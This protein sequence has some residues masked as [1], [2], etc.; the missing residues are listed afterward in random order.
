MFR[1]ARTLAI[2]GLA[3]V[4]LAA[5]EPPDLP[6]PLQ[7]MIDTER[8]FAETASRKGIRDSFL[9]YFAPDSVAFI[10]SPV[11]A[12]DRLL[13]QPPRPA[14]EYELRWEPRAGDAASSGDLGWLTGPSTFI[15]HTAAD[16]APQHGNY[17]SIWRRQPDGAWRV[18]IDVGA[19]QPSPTPFPDGFTQVAPASRYSRQDT[20][21]SA[22]A[23]LLAADR[24]LDAALPGG[25]PA[26]YA[27]RLEPQ[28]RLH[29]PGVTTPVG[30]A[31]IGRWLEAHAAGMTAET[32]GGETSAAGDLGYT[33]GTYALPEPSA[34]HGAYVRVWAR[35]AA[36]EWRLMAD[37]TQPSPR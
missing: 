3:A 20:P 10:P 27:P 5:L 33:H 14:S 37:V 29:R 35:N 28:S 4:P 15:D 31:A 12:R 30:P 2:A 1:A 8:A 25:A 22:G 26:A 11:P 13:R 18:Y 9:E 24:A 34:E 16:A 23:A 32:Q 17:L 6:A 36:G 19:P 7:A 21:A